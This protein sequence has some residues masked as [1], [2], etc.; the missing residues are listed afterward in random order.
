M[1]ERLKGLF[2]IDNFDDIN[3]LLVG[4]GGVGS[5]CFEVL[6]RSGI[7]NITIIDFDSYEESNLNRQLHSNKNNIGLK[8]V[9][10]LKEYARN[11]NGNI[12]VVTKDEFINA[13]SIIDYE[14]Y[15]YIIDA[16]DSINA[17][18]L[19]ITKAKEYNIPIISSLGVGNR[20]NP[21]DLIVTKLSKTSG[22]PLG[23]KLKYELKKV[24]FTKDLKVIFSKESPIKA[25]PVSSYIGVSAYAG[26]LLADT[27]IKDLTN[28]RK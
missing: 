26:I 4:V 7:R 22:D 9:D 23:K 27:V 15:D 11:I 5:V 18:V 28:E 14:K 20:K 1:Y 3:I 13:D 6:I 21:S 19:L 24:G 2:N 16:C 8:K 12:N 17:K 25:N 10:V